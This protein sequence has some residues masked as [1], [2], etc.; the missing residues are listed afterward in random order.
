MDVQDAHRRGREAAQRAR[1]SEDPI[2]VAVTLN[3]L[4]LAEHVRRSRRRSSRRSG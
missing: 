3:E 1:R 2:F 4:L